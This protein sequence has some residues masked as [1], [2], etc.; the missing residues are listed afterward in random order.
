MVPA[1]LRAAALMLL[2]AAAPASASTASFG[3]GTVSVSGGAEANA[4]TVTIEGTRV[5]VDDTAGMTAGAGCAEVSATRV[6]CPLADVVATSLGDGDDAFTGSW[7]A[8]RV[9]A[10]AGSD[11]VATGGGNDSFADDGR[12]DARVDLGDGTDAVSYAGLRTGVTVDLSDR[13][14]DGP[15]GGQDPLAGVEDVTGTAHDDLIEGNR[16][17][18]ILTGGGGEDELHGR[19][20]DDQVIGGP[21]SDQL[22]GGPG[23]DEVVGGAFTDLLDGGWGDDDLIGYGGPGT[24]DGV[25]VVDYSG[26]ARQVVADVEWGGGERGESDAYYGVVG[27]IGGRGDDELTGTA[28]TDLLSGRAG[29]DR[30]YGRGGSDVLAGGGGGDLI[31]ALDGGVDYVLCGRGHDRGRADRADSLTA[32]EPQVRVR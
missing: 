25:D 10:G 24:D 5:L 27:I 18:N 26:R 3:S 11:T 13:A 1:S 31:E 22:H 19:R 17:D 32:C 28:G 21:A 29:R 16:D 15:D 23:D 2:L 6:S 12:S 30:L 7:E 9:D 4:V 14:P 20:G 8:D